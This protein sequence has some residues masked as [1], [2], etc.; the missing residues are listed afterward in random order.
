[1]QRG[2]SEDFYETSVVEQAVVL[3][4]TLGYQMMVNSP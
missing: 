3:L 2:R 1:M 4:A